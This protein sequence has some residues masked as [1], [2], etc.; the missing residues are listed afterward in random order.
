MSVSNI[1]IFLYEQ[2]E[3]ELRIPNRLSI[4]TNRIEN[5]WI[6][7]AKRANHTIVRNI[8]LNLEVNL[9][10]RCLLKKT[11][12]LILLIRRSKNRC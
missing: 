11:K 6:S 7:F 8:V 2:G 12:C 3:S 1:R 4:E 9:T 10:P 5:V